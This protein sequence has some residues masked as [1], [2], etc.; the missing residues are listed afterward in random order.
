MLIRYSSLICPVPPLPARTTPKAA[1]DSS[2]TLSDCGPL[3]LAKQV[4]SLMRHRHIYIYI[5]IDIYIC[6]YNVW[7]LMYIG[8]TL[9]F[10]VNATTAFW[11][12]NKQIN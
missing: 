5:Y 7:L 4:H 2:P 11:T 10:I 12:L 6:I 9:L 8:T 3:K 1:E